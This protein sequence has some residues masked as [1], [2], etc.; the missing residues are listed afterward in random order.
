MR[1]LLDDVRGF[2]FT[3]QKVI[4]SVEAALGYFTCMTVLP[5]FV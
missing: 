2:G 3:V 4:V 1:K 5:L